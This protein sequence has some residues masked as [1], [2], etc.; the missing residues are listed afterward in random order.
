MPEP[1]YSQGKSPWNPLDWRL[2]GPQCRS[3]C[4]GEEK[5]SHPLLG[6]KP[7]IIYPVAQRYA[8]ELPRLRY[9]I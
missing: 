5:N 1:L 4:G 9:V 3:E 7:P 6:L 2:G 8:R